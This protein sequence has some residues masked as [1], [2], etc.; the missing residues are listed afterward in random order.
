MTDIEIKTLKEAIENAN[1][2]SFDIFDTLL[3]R[4]VNRPEDIFVMLEKLT[5]IEGFAKKREELQ[6]QASMKAER[7]CGLPHA[8]LDYIYN[9]IS[10]NMSEDADFEKIKQLEIELERDALFTNKEIKEIYDYAKAKNK[11]VIAVSDMYL[12]KKDIKVYL[13]DN[14]YEELDAIYVSADEHKT[15]YNGDIFKYVAEKEHVSCDKI[16]HIGDNY[17]SDYVN[18]VKAGVKAFH[19][20]AY[21]IGPLKKDKFPAVNVINSVTR[22]SDDFW[23]NLG[24]KVGGPLYSGIYE[25]FTKRIKKEKYDKIFFLARD[26]YILYNICKERHMEN[27]D[28][29]YVS[30]RGLLLA[31]IT[32]LDNESLDLLPPYT[33]GQTVKEVLEYLNVKEVCTKG[34]TQAGFSGI[35]AKIK[36]RED[37]ARFKKIY[38]ANEEA[39]LKRCEYERQNA[40]KYF[41]EKGFMDVDSI[42]FDCGWNGSSQYLLD[43][44]LDAAGY[45]GSNQFLYIGIKNSEKSKVQL[46]DKKYDTYIFD[47]DKNKELQSRVMQ[48]VVLFELFFGAP[49][50]SLWYYGEDGPVLEKYGKSEHTAGITKGVMAY[51]ENVLDFYEKYNV[52]ISSEDACYSVERLVNMPT[53]DEAVN[54][55]NVKNVDG[56]VKT[57][58]KEKYIAKLGLF[59]YM[60]NPDME[61]YWLQGLLVRPDI[62]KI[63]KKKLAKKYDVDYEAFAA[64]DEVTISTDNIEKGQ[65]KDILEDIKKKE[66]KVTYEY[67]K[68]YMDGEISDPY[69][70]WREENEKYNLKTEPLAYRPLISSVIPV[71]NVIDE[72]LIECIESILNQTYDNFE[73]ILVDD[74]SSWE[75][76]RDI[77]KKYENNE[78]VHII[79][80]KENGHISKAT[81]DG[82]AIAKGEFIAFTDCDDVLA[83]NAFYEMAKKLNENPELDFIYSDEDKLTEDGKRRHSPFFKPEWSPDTFMSIMFTNHLAIYRRSIVEEVGGLR[84]EYNGAQDYDFTLRFMEHTDNKRVGHIPKVLYY[85]RERPESIASNPEAKPYALEAVK[86][87]KIDA[88]RR[89]HIDGNVVYVKELYQYRVEYENKNNPL[90]S[91]IIPSKDNY[92]MLKRCVESLRKITTYKNYEIIV[93]DNGSNDENKALIEKMLSDN[94]A[95]YYYEPMKFNFSKMCNMGADRA[96]GEYLLFLN[97]D[98]EIFKPRWLEL[99]VG[100]ASLDYVGAV[101]AKLYYPNSNI[102]Q[103]AG[104]V[105]LPIGPTHKLIGMSDSQTYYFARNKADYNYLVVT[106]A[107]LILSADKYREVNGFDE[108]L[109]VGYNDVD[110][111]MKLY[112]A[113]YYNVLRNDVVLYHYESASRGSDDISKEKMERLRTERTRLYA[114]HP[115][116]EGKDPFYNINLTPDKANY[117]IKLDEYKELSE[118]TPLTKAV[119]ENLKYGEVKAN[120]D[121]ISLNH[122]IT[123]EGWQFIEKDKCNDESEVY[124]AITNAGGKGY[125]VKTER[126]YRPDIRAAYPNDKKI[127]I[128]GFVCKIDAKM[129]SRDVEQYYITLVIKSKGLK[130]N[131][132]Y[133]MDKSIDMTR[134]YPDIRK[135]DTIRS[136]DLNQIP[137]HPLMTNF[138]DIECDGDEIQIRG[139]A[140]QKDIGYNDNYLKNIILVS[141]KGESLE[142][143]AS[144]EE[145][146]DLVTAYR[147]IPNIRF[148]GLKKKIKIN[149]LKK[150][151]NRFKMG[152]IVRDSF[153]NDVKYIMTEK[154]LDLS[155]EQVSDK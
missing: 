137:Q 20:K 56:F 7:E 30:R 6:M 64:G 144:R 77:L 65:I 53:K 91:I 39:F 97:D 18:A 55:G 127:L 63:L 102:I 12:M 128:S 87:A 92:T 62:N 98:I 27:I 22:N 111:C 72:Q 99:L 151:G 17:Q 107:C 108:E 70:R 146:A 119:R 117:D 71:Y 57:K 84:S 43:R 118:I 73:L 142:I 74:N 24:A 130:G 134:I 80:R 9:Y 75:S 25:W 58:N 26:G 95:S 121:T 155:K 110:L 89:R 101:G 82:I 133:A 124:L 29:L 47:I 76:V 112:E 83:P 79:Y 61:M 96:K 138:E 152:I 122:I 105:N 114:K 139:W 8:D 59:E 132:I 33:I 113:G 116:L 69:K 129:L 135:A 106:G 32:E 141:D 2:I 68:K 34:I 40:L 88:L 48:A 54:I 145:R 147:R 66:G 28:Y 126:K 37:M 10:M 93:I 38:K 103:H 45:K 1:V 143:V 41:T 154:I 50:E 19:Y 153:S 78:K 125:L 36:N 52:D 136:I 86:N 42:V 104:V 100:H 44:F 109:T 131:V 51:L 123:I 94:G 120:I 85:W 5:G 149:E 90:V 49:H 13:D 81:N 4:K 21:S 23:Y 16:L 67:M 11:K 14:G 15:K 46:H 115:E 150:Y 148:S 31:G 3:F 140:I 35:N 60:F